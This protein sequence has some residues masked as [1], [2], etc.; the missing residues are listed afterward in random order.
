MAT[1]IRNLSAFTAAAKFHLHSAYRPLEYT[2]INRRQI[3]A[4]NN[5]AFKKD[6]LL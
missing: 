1:P 5:F 2:L 6:P 4:S 3:F